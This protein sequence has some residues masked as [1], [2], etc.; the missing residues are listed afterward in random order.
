MRIDKSLMTGSTT[1]LVLS[2]LSREEM[3]GYQMITELARRSDH[4]FELKEGTLYPILHG[5]EA[6]RLV[7]VREREAESGRMRKYYRITK[8]GLKLLEQKK[9][10]WAFFT[11][12]VN[13][14]LCGT[15]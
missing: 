5:L 15:I 10:E 4:T 6:D 14:V 3:Y 12:K 2:L 11:E 13:A 9:E 7:T 8:R 1:M